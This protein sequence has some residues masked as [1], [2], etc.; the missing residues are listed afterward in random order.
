MLKPQ[1]VQISS[2]SSEYVTVRSQA[3]GVFDEIVRIQPILGQILYVPNKTV[4]NGTIITG[5]GFVLQ[6]KDATN[7]EIPGASEIAIGVI[8]PNSPA[9]RPEY[10][11]KFPYQVFA[12]LATGDQSNEKYKSRIAQAVDLNIH[13]LEIREDDKLILEVKSSVVVDWTGGK[14]FFDMLLGKVN[15]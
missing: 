9:N 11:T 7:T 13:P 5:F 6:L 8:R 3:A 12:G 2:S 4:V 10:V 1:N 14:S 15:K